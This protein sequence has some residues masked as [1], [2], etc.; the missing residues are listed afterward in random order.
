MSA[1][2]LEAAGDKYYYLDVV[3]VCTP[4]A[5]FDI[6][7]RSPCVV[8]EVTSPSTTRN[9]RGEKLEAIGAFPLRTYLVVD[10]RRLRVEHDFE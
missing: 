2:R 1:M 4:I 8:V 10:H 9:D 7:A 5:E 3:V 6:V